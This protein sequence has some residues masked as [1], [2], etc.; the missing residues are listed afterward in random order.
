MLLKLEEKV[1]GIEQAN[2]ADIVYI[3]HAHS[4]H[5]TNTK[6]EIFSSEKTYKLLK[7]RGLNG[8]GFVERLENVSLFPSGHILGS[9]QIRIENKDCITVYTGDFKL[10]DG[11]T[12]NGGEILECDKLYIDCTFS[13]PIFIFPEKE[14]IEAEII[15][16]IDKEK[17]SGRNIIIGAYSVGKAQEVIKLLNENS[18]IPVVSEKI[19]KICSVYDESG[20][21]LNRTIGMNDGF[22]EYFVG[23]VE[24]GEIN[25]FKKENFSLALVT[26]WAMKYKFGIKAF[27]LSD[28]AGF[29]EIIKYIKESKAKEVICINSSNYFI[30]YTRKIGIN[31]KPLI[32]I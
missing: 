18:I 16:W 2:D 23:V 1:I 9:T 25:S 4:D 17:K 13:E 24:L 21:K 32:R 15:E 3:S 28:H 6:K 20:I 31:S 12:T 10:R 27:P 11:F 7:A 19:D 8:N 29:Y 22:D 14:E 30:E 5:I 26:G